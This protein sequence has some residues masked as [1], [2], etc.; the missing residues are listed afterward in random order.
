[1]A[2]IPFPLNEFDHFTTCMQEILDGEI[3]RLSIRLQLQE[4]QTEK[5]RL[6]YQESLDRLSALKY[7]SRLRKGLLSRE[8]FKQKVQL[9]AL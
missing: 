4:R 1:M 7:I 6:Q 9:T 8:D 3:S 5:E 2:L